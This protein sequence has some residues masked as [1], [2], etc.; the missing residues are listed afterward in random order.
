M[1][2]PLLGDAGRSV[3]TEDEKVQP[4]IVWD[5]VGNEN[6][7]SDLDEMCCAGKRLVLS[8][9]VSAWEPGEEN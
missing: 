8:V 5:F 4:H 3:H 6:I 2:T 1:K 7:F 9:G